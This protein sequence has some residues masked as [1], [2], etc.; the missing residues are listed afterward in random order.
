MVVDYGQKHDIPY[1]IVRPGMVYGPG[2]LAITGRVGIGTFGL[3]LHLGGSNPIPF[4]YVD[5]CAEA[6]VLAGLRP[7]INGEGFNVVDDNLPSC[8]KFLRLYKR[9][10]KRFP[11]LYV[12]KI[13]SYTLCS[14][15]ERYS[16]W[17]EGQLPPAFNRSRWN[18]V[19]KKTGYTNEKLKTRLGWRPIISTQEGLRRYCEACRAGEVH[20]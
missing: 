3:F 11:S 13:L 1:V 6:I 5:N 10:V 14:L 2:N 17:S 8:R 12:P 16:S 9:D 4:T 7:G 15:W 18:A 19:W 20:A